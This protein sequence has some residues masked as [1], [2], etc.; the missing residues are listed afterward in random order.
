MYPSFE[1]SLFAHDV[2]F[3]ACL[4]ALQHGYLGNSEPVRLQE[5]RRRPRWRKFSEDT[6]RLLGPLR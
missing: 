6:F 3:T 2:D 4:L 1:I 5:W